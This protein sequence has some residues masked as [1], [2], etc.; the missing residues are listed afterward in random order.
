M[1]PF[2]KMLANGTVMLGQVLLCFLAVQKSKALARFVCYYEFI[3]SRIVGDADQ[4]AAPVGSPSVNPNAHVVEVFRFLCSRFRAEHQPKAHNSGVYRNR[5][6][7][8]RWRGT[9][10]VLLESAFC[11]AVSWLLAGIAFCFLLGEAQ[12]VGADQGFTTRNFNEASR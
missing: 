8:G 5:V 12:K 10:A 6:D 9:G 11:L 2:I 1:A 4:I 3:R 7:W